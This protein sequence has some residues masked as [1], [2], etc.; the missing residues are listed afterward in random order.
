VSRTLILF[1]NAAFADCLLFTFIQLFVKTAMSVISSE[2]LFDTKCLKRLLRG[3]GRRVSQ[4][5]L[6]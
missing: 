1:E 5:F 4:K 2:T 3:V 6:N